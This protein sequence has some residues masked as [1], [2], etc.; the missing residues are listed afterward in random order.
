MVV[1]DRFQNL[2]AIRIEN[3]GMRII[4]LPEN[5][6]KV[7]SIYDKQKNFELLFQNPKQQFERP[8]IYSNFA[9]FDA[10]G[11]DDA[12]PTIDQCSIDVN[13]QKIIYPDHGEIWSARF[14]SVIEGDY[15]LMT[16]QSIILPYRYSKR[17]SLHD[18]RL[19]CSYKIENTGK[20]SFPF[21]WAFHCLVNY[22]EDMKLIFPRDIEHVENVCESR[23]FGEVGAIYS[24]PVDMIKTG[25]MYDFTTVPPRTPKS[26]EKYYIKEKITEGRCGY[27][28]PSKD[29]TAVIEYDAEKLPYLGFWVTAGG[30]RGDYNCALEPATGYYDSVPVADKNH[31]SCVLTPGEKFEFALT[32]ELS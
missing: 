4:V 17:L 31:S 14:D 15:A 29:V 21:L 10:S 25:Q 2:S 12:F 23:R 32:I 7:A 28:Y 13:G 16:Y 24:A 5:G 8:K 1:L 6:G 3:E 9:D 27:Y 26:M 19:V 11:F 22:N 30:F 18:K 20:V